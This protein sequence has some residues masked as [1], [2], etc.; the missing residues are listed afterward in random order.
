MTDFNNDTCANS[1]WA[2]P[3]NLLLSMLA[4]QGNNF[5]N[6]ALEKIIAVK[7]YGDFRYNHTRKVLNTNLYFEATPY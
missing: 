4:D 5:K 6:E 1:Y 3:E 2:H 7:G